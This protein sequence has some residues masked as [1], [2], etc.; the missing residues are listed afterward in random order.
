MHGIK[1][2]AY[3]SWNISGI[4]QTL[5]Q[6]PNLPT[7]H[8]PKWNITHIFHGIF[9]LYSTGQPRTPQCNIPHIFHRA[10]PKD[11]ELEYSTYIPPCYQFLE[12][13]TYIPWN[14]HGIKYSTYI[15]CNIPLIFQ[16]GRPKIYSTHIPGLPLE[17]NPSISPSG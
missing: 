4:F 9:H 3:I 6:M 14:M 17:H 13:S 15:P 7:P 16:P 2:S 1:Y 8:C 11:R 5:Q 10:A 12:Y